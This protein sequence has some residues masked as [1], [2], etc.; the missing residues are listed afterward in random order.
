MSGIMKELK[1]GSHFI[2]INCTETFQITDPTK[3][4]VSFFLSVNRNGISTLVI[5]K[6]LKN[7]HHFVNIVNINY[8][9]KFQIIDHPKFGSLAF[10]V[11][12]EMEYQ[13]QS[14]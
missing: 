6:T 5:M 9:E 11:S 10:Q 3:V 13:H 1:N 4:W 2:N 8:M 7:G 12:T 14:L